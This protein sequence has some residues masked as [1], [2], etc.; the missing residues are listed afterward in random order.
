MT[1]LNLLS[2]GKISG[3]IFIAGRFDV[4]L[5]AVPEIESAGSGDCPRSYALK[6]I[7]INPK[8]AS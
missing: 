6:T 7:K 2:K 3:F 5:A 4:K 8:K 1:A